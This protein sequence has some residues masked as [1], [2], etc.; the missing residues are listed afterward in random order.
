MEE[1][2]KVQTASRRELS[3]TQAWLL[4]PQEEAGIVLREPGACIPEQPDFHGQQVGGPHSYRA[5]SQKIHPAWLHP[6]L[7][8][9]ECGF[10]AHMP[11]MQGGQWGGAVLKPPRLK[12]PRG[13]CCFL[14]VSQEAHLLGTVPSS[15]TDK[16]SELQKGHA[17]LGMSHSGRACGKHTNKQAYFSVQAG[18]SR[19]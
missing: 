2:A 10:S 16:V 13:P 18:P 17:R 4:P 5:G 19:F 11:L 8:S 1:S 7:L 3:S 14:P 15:F 6:A 9:S 12:V